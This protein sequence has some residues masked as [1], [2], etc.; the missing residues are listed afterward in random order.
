MIRVRRLKSGH[1]WRS[2][3]RQGLTDG[4]NLIRRRISVTRE[5]LLVRLDIPE[6]DDAVGGTGRWDALEVVAP[7]AADVV[8]GQ[9]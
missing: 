4:R 1:V 5:C 7:T 3:L 6:W 8:E 2:S 9:R